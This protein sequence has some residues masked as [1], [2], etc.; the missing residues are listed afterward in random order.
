MFWWIGGAVLLVVLV[1]AWAYDRKRGRHTV[2]R[3]NPEAEKGYAAGVQGAIFN[4]QTPG[5]SL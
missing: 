3:R 2:D 1:L 4:E 5:G